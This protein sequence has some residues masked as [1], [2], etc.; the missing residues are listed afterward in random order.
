VAYYEPTGWVDSTIY[1]TPGYR[2]YRDAVY[3]NGAMFLDALRELVGER[4]FFNFLR[5]Y[6]T[7]STGRLATAEDFFA[8]LGENS[9]AD[10]SA[11]LEEY[12]ENR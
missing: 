11:L 12:F 7:R 1:N 10:W 6:T 8:I 5:D 3:L 2:L 9:D 4:A